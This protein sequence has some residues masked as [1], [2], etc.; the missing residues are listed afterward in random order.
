MME[1]QMIKQGR[2]SGVKKSV[3]IGTICAYAKSTPVPFQEED[4]WNGYPEETDAP[5]G[6]GKKILLVLAQAY[7]RQ[8]GFNAIFP[9]P[10]NLIPSVWV[11]WTLQDA[12][13]PEAVPTTRKGFPKQF[14]SLLSERPHP[15]H[16]AQGENTKALIRE[17]KAKY[18]SSSQSSFKL[19]F[20][21]FSSPY[22]RI[23]L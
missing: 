4:L 22:R 12:P 6:L 7:C 18:P 10:V 21:I 2:L 23:C 5:Y 14:P 20:R 9:P 17:R 16:S 3:A 15:P 19:A 8:Y 1:I 13:R 11:S